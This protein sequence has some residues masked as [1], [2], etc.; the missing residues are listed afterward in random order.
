[1]R[2]IPLLLLLASF[3]EAAGTRNKIFRNMAQSAYDAG[4][5]SMRTIYG[6]SP[7]E[8]GSDDDLKFDNIYEPVKSDESFR[9]TDKGKEKIHKGKEKVSNVVSTRKALVA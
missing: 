6:S 4:K 8:G 3:H 7:T 1:M 5:E 9:L 2:F